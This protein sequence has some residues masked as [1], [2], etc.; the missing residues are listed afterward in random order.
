VSEGVSES[1]SCG[2]RRDR[3]NAQG[4]G[5]G[6]SHMAKINLLKT[7]D[8]VFNAREDLPMLRIKPGGLTQLLWCTYSS[9][10]AKD[11]PMTVSSLFRLQACA[12]HAKRVANYV[13]SSC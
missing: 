12:I 2:F 11:A 13:M 5:S 3:W 7:S 1:I 6:A 9:S 4:T 8:R 10:G